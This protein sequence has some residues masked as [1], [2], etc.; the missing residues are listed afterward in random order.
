MFNP[1]QLFLYLCFVWPIG[2]NT[3]EMFGL[4]TFTK[5]VKPHIFW[6]RPLENLQ[7]IA[8]FN[9]F[10]P[11]FGQNWAFAALC[12]TC[13]CCWCCCELNWSFKPFTAHIALLQDTFN[14]A[15]LL[16][17]ALLCSLWHLF[18]LFLQTDYVSGS[19]TLLTGAVRLILPL[20]GHTKPQLPLPPCVPHVSA[21]TAAL[22]RRVDGAVVL[23]VRGHGG[24]GLT[25]QAAFQQQTSCPPKS[26][27]SG[28]KASLSAP[29]NPVALS[30]LGSVSA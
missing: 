12:T 28:W 19:L 20:A 10:N 14:K 11:S 4:Q 16:I 27:N 25:P 30:I 17:P 18:T 5:A 7:N 1:R 24:H 23:Q 6:H 8:G 3:P 21:V 13:L 15:E 26:Q 22:P 9:F 29:I 2:Q